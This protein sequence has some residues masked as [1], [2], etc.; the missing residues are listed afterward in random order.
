MS[1]IGLHALIYAR[2]ADAVRR[3]FKALGWRSVNAGDDW[4]IFAT[5]PAELAVHPVR[6]KGSQEFYLMCDD[7]AAT[8]AALRRK[9]IRTVGGI[10]DRGWGLVT[11]LRLPG[12]ER[13]GLYEPRHRMA[14]A[15]P[16]TGGRSSSRSRPPASARVSG[17]AAGKRRRP[18]R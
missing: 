10:H 5:P 9:G 6:A 16:R 3:V 14:I 18:R 4:L 11:A 1:I 12:G 13:L 8:V 2:R 7:L 15:R 17:A